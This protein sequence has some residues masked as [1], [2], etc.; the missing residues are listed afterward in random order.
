MKKSKQFIC[1]AL[2]LTAVFLIA[3]CTEKL[4]GNTSETGNAVTASLYNPGGSPTVHAK[5]RFIPINYNPRTGGLGK[6]AAKVDSATT[7]ANGTYTAKLDTGA[8]NVLAAGDSGVVY[9]DSIVVVKDSTVRP[10]ADTLKSPGSIRG[11]VRLQP[12]DDARKVFILAMGTNTFS[13]PEDAAGNFALADMAEGKYKVRIMSILDNYDVLD[14][15]LEIRSGKSDSLADTIVLPYTGIP[16]SVG[17]KISYDTLKQIV[18]LTWNKPVN[19]R[20]V[21]SY[22]IYRKRSDSTDFVKINGGV[23]DTIFS[24][25]TGVQDQT[26]EYRVAAVDSNTTEGT[27]SAG[28]S[29]KVVGAF[30]LIDSIGGE[31]TQNGQFAGANDVTALSNGNIVVLDYNRHYAQIFDSNGVFLKRFG[32]EGN[33]NGQFQNPIA[34]TQDDSNQVYILDEIGGRVQEFD[35]DGNFKRMWTV[36]QFCRGVKY[37]KNKIYVA[38]RY[39]SGLLTI[40]TISDSV[41]LDS[42]PNIEPYGIDF[43]NISQTLFIVDNLNNRVIQTDTIGNILKSWGSLGNKLGKFDYPTYLKFFSNDRIYITDSKNKRVQMFNSNGEVIASLG[44]GIFSYPQGIALSGSKIIYVADLYN[45]QVYK[46]SVNF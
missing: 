17:L 34:I 40:N 9:Q 31:G 32:Q 41:K 14:T 46:F 37:V 12:G 44:L 16:V 33:S 15:S 25:S 5:I 1:M 7:D 20:K 11:V 19:G 27:K 38:S 3:G 36:G 18:T 24:D 39:P 8:Y 28:V 26:Y 6:I 10:P 29:V 35:K 13:W 43:E 21:V 42:I 2:A 22:S 4:A 45:F 23:T 30:S